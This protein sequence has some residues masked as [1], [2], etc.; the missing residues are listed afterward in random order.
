[1][2]LRDSELTVG[3]HALTR[4]RLRLGGE[5]YRCYTGRRLG[6]RRPSGRLIA[7]AEGGHRRPF[8]SRATVKLRRIK[9]VGTDCGWTYFAALH[10]SELAPFH[11]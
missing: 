3:C 6:D 5:S 1:M 7:R 11:R 2:P 9:P 4:R 8:L 10:E